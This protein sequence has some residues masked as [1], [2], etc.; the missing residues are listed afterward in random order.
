MENMDMYQNNNY[1][2]GRVKKQTLSLWIPM[3]NHVISKQFALHEPLRLD[4]RTEV[5][6]DSVISGSGFAANIDTDQDFFILKI[7]ELQCKHNSATSVDA[8]D[9]VGAANHTPDSM[10]HIR[11]ILYDSI[12]IPNIRPVKGVQVNRGNKYNYISSLNPTVLTSLTV[13]LGF[14]KYNGLATPLIDYD[15][16]VG[17]DMLIN[18]VFI[19]QD[20]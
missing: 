6:L 18:L 5:Y 2:N 9:P 3:A 15:K 11:S 14:L 8:L 4:A 1:R 10:E 7:D 16:Q 17:A 12:V 19:T 20:D 13:S